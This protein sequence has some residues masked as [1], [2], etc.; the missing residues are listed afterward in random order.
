MW[1]H[2]CIPFYVS[3]YT[4]KEAS[5]MSRTES[6]SIGMRKAG[7]CICALSRGVQQL[8]LTSHNYINTIIWI[9]DSVLGGAGRR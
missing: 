9:H 8:F 6:C 2:C 4:W 7:P 1:V 3:V 5:Y